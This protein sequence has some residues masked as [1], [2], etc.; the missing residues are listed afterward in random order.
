MARAPSERADPGR[1][2]RAAR[3]GATPG[4]RQPRSGAP[5]VAGRPGHDPAGGGRRRRRPAGGG[6]ARGQWHAGLADRGALPGRGRGPARPGL[7]PWLR[8]ARPAP[9]RCER[10]GRGHPDARGRAGCPRGGADRAGRG[11]CRAGRGRRGRPGLPD[12]GPG[13][14]G[15]VRPRD[16]LRHPAQACGTGVSRAA[17]QRAAGG[18][19]RPPGAG[20]AA[21]PAD[22][23]QR[24][25][26]GRPLPPGPGE[27]PARRGLL[28]RGRDLGRHRARGH[29]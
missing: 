14:A 27:C 10:A 26:H 20:P 23:D 13:A 5:R 8:P 4:E 6:T 22:P 2:A 11:Q 15:R 1:G 12:Q 21:E 3:P 19:E 16:P 18:R 17:A 9:A 24:V 25:R 7:G 29:R 28:R